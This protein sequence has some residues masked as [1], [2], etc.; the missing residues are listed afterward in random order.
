[1]SSYLR[2]EP[3]RSA[4]VSRELEVED[5]ASEVITVLLADD[6][7]I[8][9]AGLRLLLEAEQGFSVV[10]EAGDVPSVMRKVRGHRPRVLILD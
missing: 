7:A 3:L 10:A 1:M 2:T 8:L 9:R 6:H 5:E 4:T